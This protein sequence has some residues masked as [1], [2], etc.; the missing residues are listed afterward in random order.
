MTL[1]RHSED[2]L[3]NSKDQ[4]MSLANFCR[5]L[6]DLVAACVGA[7]AEAGSD[8]ELRGA[9]GHA[10]AVGCNEGNAAVTDDDS[11]DAGGARCNVF[12]SS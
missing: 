4:G 8:R 2:L 3:W 10:P 7:A 5:R 9:E 12:A 1:L 11:A 6:A